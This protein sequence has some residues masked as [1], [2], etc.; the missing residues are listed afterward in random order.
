MKLRKLM[1]EADHEVWFRIVDEG[2]GEKLD[3]WS[4]DF[5][6][7]HESVMPALAPLLNREIGGDGFYLKVGVDPETGCGCVPI[8]AVPLME[9][10]PRRRRTEGKRC[11]SQA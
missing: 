4:A 6:G 10:M 7:A 9:R 1:E 5:H 3:V 2:T 11:L 8:V